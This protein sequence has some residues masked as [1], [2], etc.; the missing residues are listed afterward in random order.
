[1]EQLQLTADMLRRILSY[2]Q[3]MPQ[4]LEFL[5]EFGRKLR[6]PIARFS[7]FFSDMVARDPAIAHHLPD[8]RSGYQYQMCYTM[9]SAIYEEDWEAWSFRQVAVY[10]NFDVRTAKQLWILGDPHET[11]SEVIAERYNDSPG[12]TRIPLRSIENAFR[13]SL[14]IHLVYIHECTMNWRT[15]ISLLEAAV[16]EQVGPDPQI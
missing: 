15:R 5:F 14:D 8:G 7:G 4:F 11:L 9:T 6:I 3:V 12:N 13:A 16:W 10:H 2:H 1:M